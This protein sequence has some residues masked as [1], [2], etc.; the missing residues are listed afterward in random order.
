MLRWWRVGGAG[1][2]AE[3]HP[4]LMHNPLL[5]SCR[6]F[7]WYLALHDCTLPVA[8]QRGSL[9]NS[10]VLVY[11]WSPLLLVLNPRTPVFCNMKRPPLG[12]V[13][14][15]NIAN[16]HQLCT[17][18]SCSCSPSCSSSPLLLY[19]ACPERF[20]RS[21][22]IGWR[23]PASVSRTLWALLYDLLSSVS[24]RCCWT[25][26]VRLLRASSSSSSRWW[27]LCPLSSTS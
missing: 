14:S 8:A 11:V 22:G 21:C 19:P 4:P 26:S 7:R 6:A 1:R 15:C 9:G 3:P 20:A 16:P 5:H 24:S 12:L 17:R 10:M 18:W 2:A 27:Q 23:Q 25:S 13:P